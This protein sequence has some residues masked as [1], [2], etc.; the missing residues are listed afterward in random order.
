MQFCSCRD[1]QI[2]HTP[3]QGPE[4]AEP[5]P[6]KQVSSSYFLSGIALVSHQR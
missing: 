5:Q 2:G 6:C 3:L 1:D 4:P